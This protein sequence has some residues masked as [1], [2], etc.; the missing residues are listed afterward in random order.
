MKKVIAVLLV[1]VAYV[2]VA[3]AGEEARDSRFIANNNG[4]VLDTET[5]LMWASKDNGSDIDFQDA[6]RYCE[7]YRGGNYT[8][9]RMPTWHELNKMVDGSK[10][11]D[12]GYYL[13]SFIR[14]TG[15]CVWP[16][17][18][19]QNNGQCPTCKY[20]H[21]DLSYDFGRSCPGEALTDR[22]GRRVLP[23]RSSK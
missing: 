16:S 1:L 3:F 2:G 8:D 6:K 14:L 11:N 22:I 4:T 19:G 21:I 10:K 7:N 9:W 15:G 13:T 23:V 20:N 18:F 12:H 17:D 5:N